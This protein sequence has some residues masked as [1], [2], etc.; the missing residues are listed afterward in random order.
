MS[1]FWTELR[2]LAIVSVFLLLITG[3]SVGLAAL[4][5]MSI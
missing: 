3:A 1:Q 5:A 2:E 4:I